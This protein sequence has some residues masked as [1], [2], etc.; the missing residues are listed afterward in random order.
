MSSC[1]VKVLFFASARESAGTA[2]LDLVVNASDAEGVKAS[3]VLRELMARY[4]TL[5][6]EGTQ[7]S[8]AV[9]QNYLGDEDIVLKEGDEVA[10]LPPIA[11]G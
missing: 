4:P 1:T 8:V 9:N 6:F 2:K 5:D 3:D 7:I 10:L 11:G